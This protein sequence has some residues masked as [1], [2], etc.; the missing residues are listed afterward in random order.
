MKNYY[1]IAIF[2]LFLVACNNDDDGYGPTYDYIFTENS[3]LTVVSYDT[4]TYIKYGEVQPGEKLVFK[5]RY[6]AGEDLATYDAG[7]TEWI[8]FEI[9]PE[10][11]R[12]S[13]TDDELLTIDAVYTKSCF[14][15]F[16]YDEAKD[17]DPV[18]TISGEKLSDN[19]WKIKIDVT[20]YNE[21]HKVIDAKFK[22]D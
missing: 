12:F 1:F 8:R 10:L 5:Y 21:D 4:E 17:V 9:D 2:S 16:E 22:R 3:E 20:F 11:E 7:F 6:D 15:Y 18:G 14:C 13:Y 19:S